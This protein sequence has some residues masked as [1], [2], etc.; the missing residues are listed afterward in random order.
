VR[1]IS[2]GG[3]MSVL[4]EAAPTHR[5]DLI[6]I[7]EYPESHRLNGLVLEAILATTLRIEA[8]AIVPL[9]PFTTIG[10]PDT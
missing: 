8:V 1:V 5:I 10:Q 4:Y 3:L 6:L 9:V 7:R 2:I